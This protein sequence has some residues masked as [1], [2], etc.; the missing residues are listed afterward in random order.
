V[1]G[2]PEANRLPVTLAGMGEEET[3]RRGGAEADSYRIE[4]RGA[5]AVAFA[6]QRGAEQQR[7]AAWAHL[8]ALAGELRGAWSRGA[9]QNA[10][11]RA[12]EGVKARLEADVDMWRAEDAEYRR[13]R[14]QCHWLGV[15]GER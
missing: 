10:E 7:G 13:F 15:S 12:A 3:I 8:D 9:S 4:D 14:E 11:L 2:S 1:V 6:F 5:V